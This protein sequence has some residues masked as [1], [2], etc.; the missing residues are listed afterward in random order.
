MFGKK[1]LQVFT[2]LS[3][4]NW[5]LAFI[6]PIQFIHEGH[7]WKVAV[8]HTRIVPAAG[9]ANS[10]QNHVHHEP[11]EG[12]KANSVLGYKRLETFLVDINF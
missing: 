9:E 3:P 6:E 8:C 5:I 7:V 10:M 12:W 11:F 2:L 4:A 1:C